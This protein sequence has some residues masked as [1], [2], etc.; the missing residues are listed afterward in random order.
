MKDETHDNIDDE[1]DE[2]ELYEIYKMSLDEKRWR[3]CAFESELKDIYYIKRP[4]GMQC[5]YDKKVNKTSKFNLLHDI[6]KHSK[7]TKN[8][9][10]HYSPILHGVKFLM[11]HLAPV[12]QIQ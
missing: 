5:I 9:N 2:D 11:E 3:K 8:I 1:V 6:L 7:H 10:S 4:D 12:K